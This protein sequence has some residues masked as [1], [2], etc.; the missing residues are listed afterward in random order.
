[1]VRWPKPARRPPPGRS[2]TVVQQVSVGLDLNLPVGTTA[3]RE[4]CDLTTDSASVTATWLSVVSWVLR[5]LAWMFAALFIAGFTS[6][7]RKT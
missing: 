7:V 4:E 3:A 5:V 2:C 6:A 1:M